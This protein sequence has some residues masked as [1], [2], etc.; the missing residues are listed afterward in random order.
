MLR[1]I[2]FNVIHLKFELIADDNVKIKNV[3]HMALTLKN[4]MLVV[5][6]VLIKIVS[7]IYI[8]SSLMRI[9]IKNI[10]HMTPLK[11]LYACFN[12]GIDQDSINGLSLVELHTMF[13]KKIKCITYGIHFKKFRCKL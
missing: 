8:W 11:I 4:Y 3:S 1:R 13:N 6:A 2:P 7:M 12:C 10:Y 9:A 5:I